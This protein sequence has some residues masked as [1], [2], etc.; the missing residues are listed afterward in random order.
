MALHRTGF[1]FLA[2]A[3]IAGLSALVFPSA[4]VSPVLPG[5]SPT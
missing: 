5:R 4:R 1:V 3:G 2:A